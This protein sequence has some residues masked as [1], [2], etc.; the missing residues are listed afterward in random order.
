MNGKALNLGVAESKKQAASAAVWFD[1]PYGGSF[2]V[3]CDAG[4]AFLAKKDRI[5]K[6]VR[7]REN[8]KKSADLPTLDQIEVVHRSYFGTY[9]VGWQKV[10][11]ADDAPIEFTE[12][13]FLR[14]CTAVD[15]LFGSISAF[16]NDKEE[17]LQEDLKARSGN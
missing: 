3:N 9:V 13:N 10:N 6:Y 12:E 14:V 2:Q 7:G 15:G 17:A 11:G 8:T 4:R 1:S 5:E 16:I